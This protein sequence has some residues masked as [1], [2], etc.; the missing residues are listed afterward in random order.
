M[1]E[2]AKVQK[3]QKTNLIKMLSCIKITSK[4][5]EEMASL[6]HAHSHGATL[7]AL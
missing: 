6:S 2:M 4:Q 5:C 3:R 7:L 1:G